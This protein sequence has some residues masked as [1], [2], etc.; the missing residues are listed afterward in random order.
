MLKDLYK[1]KMSK[2]YKMFEILRNLKL[3]QGDINSSNNLLTQNFFDRDDIGTT[4]KEKL[5]I[6]NDEIL[7]LNQ[8]IFKNS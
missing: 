2:E 4:K 8:E 6:L 1:E 7:L 5:K 3:H